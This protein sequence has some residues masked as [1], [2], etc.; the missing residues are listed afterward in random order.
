[1]SDPWTKPQFVTTR[2]T[3]PQTINPMALAEAI[4]ALLPDVVDSTDTDGD[5][6]TV[7]FKPNVTAE[8]KDAIDALIQAHDHTVVSTEE[9]R[10]Q[11]HADA[12][13][14]FKELDIDAI[15]DEKDAATQTAAILAAL[16]DIQTIL[17][18][19]YDLV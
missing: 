9:K 8:D 16:R 18:G 4:K 5:G 15:A 17:R 6:V 7:R 11:K 10:K 14:R 2:F 3:R 1:M 13:R 19:E 12:N